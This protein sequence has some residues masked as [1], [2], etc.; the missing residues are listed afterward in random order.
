MPIRRTVAGLCM[1]MLA[2]CLV[3]VGR[4]RTLQ[5]SSAQAQTDTPASK[6]LTPV[7]TWSLTIDL[8]DGTR[9]QALYTC[10]GDGNLTET[11]TAPETHPLGHGAQQSGH[12]VWEMEGDGI[13]GTTYIKLHYDREG[14]YTGRTTVRERLMI[15]KNGKVISGTLKAITADLFFDQEHEDV[16]KITGTRMSVLPL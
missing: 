15:D 5:E 1:I 3:S 4:V 7:G 16:G 11:D 12:G 10:N 6:T 9:I 13:V 2:I 8:Q 14:N